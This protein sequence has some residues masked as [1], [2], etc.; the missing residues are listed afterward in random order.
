MSSTTAEER[1][2]SDLDAVPTNEVI[3]PLPKLQNGDVVIDRDDENPNRAVVVN[4]P[5][6][7]ADEW[8]A[9]GSETVASDN[10][11]YPSDDPVVV[12][13][14]ESVL[15][16]VYPDYTGC[17]AIRMKKLVR[18]GV[19]HYSFPRSRLKQVDELDPIDV[20]LTA[21][22]PAAHHSRNF[23]LEENQTFI[24]EIGE[25]GYPDP[26]PLLRDCGD[27]YEI[28]NGHKRIWA[29]HIAGLQSIP[30]H[31]V[32]M[33]DQQAAIKWATWHLGGYTNEQLETARETLENA[34]DQ[35]LE[36][37]LSDEILS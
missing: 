30:C 8:Y 14:F 3:A 11:S 13:V 25:R 21:V 27:H 17:L 32:Y 36:D 12:V 33:N 20:D 24:E 7:P 18:D 4:T 28:L 29:S 34:I 31:C 35:P 23:S 15:R 16:D 6:V 10:P 1:T 5:F 9:Y 2:D 37:A 26:I 22:R 19:P